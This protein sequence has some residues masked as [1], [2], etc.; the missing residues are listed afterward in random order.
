MYSARPKT[1]NW[2]HSAACRDEDPELL[3]PVGTTGPALMQVAAAKA[4]CDRCPVTTECL[5]WALKHATDGIWGGLT[6]DERRALKPGRL[7]EVAA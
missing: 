1:G 4:V 6:V 2:I 7:G 5:T 3:F